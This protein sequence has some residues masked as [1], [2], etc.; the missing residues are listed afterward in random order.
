MLNNWFNI[1]AFMPHGHCFLWNP[2]LLWSMVLGNAIIALSYFSIP[3]ALLVTMR[4]QQS[5]Q[6]RWIFVMFSAF[7]FA[8]GMTH[9]ISIVTIWYPDYY[10]EA[11]VMVL[12]AVVSAT[13]AI[14]LWPIVG[15]ARAYVTNQEITNEI[16]MS[17]NEQLKGSIEALKQHH[18]DFQALN[19]MS[20]YIE[21]CNDLQEVSTTIIDTLAKLWPES[22]GSILL[23]D[24]RA[25]EFTLAGQWGDAIRCET[26]GAQAC[27][28]Y[29]LSTP[30]P[31]SDTQSHHQCLAANCGIKQKKMCWPISAGGETLGL[32]HLEGLAIPL[33]ERDRTILPLLIERAGF[34]IYSM[35]LQQSLEFKS[36]R[37]ALTELFNRHYM[38]E[39]LQIEIDRAQRNQDPLS[40]VMFDL[41]YF[42]RLNDTH[43]HEV[44]DRALRMF[45]RILRSGLRTGDMACRYGGEEFVLILPATDLDQAA[46]IADR[47]RGVLATSTAESDIDPAFANM[48][49]SAGVASLS[50]ACSTAK[51]LIH[52]ADQALYQAKEAGRNQ[53]RAVRDPEPVRQAAPAV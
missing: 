3:I 52:H 41:D 48:T 42:K 26:I 16:L 21:V 1:D 47:I 4:R 5:R 35:R 33:D 43:G 49:A 23:M 38:D 46:E 19:R 14:A 2:G 13:T 40:L 30:F 45:A 28:S 10:L 50:P 29:R 37:D 8:C 11:V 44:G 53:V 36:T 17:T 6:I 7:I 24:P 27:W 25:N 9:V 15:R 22:S 31:D 12:T 32:L 20:G 39:A 51:D 18:Q 34:A